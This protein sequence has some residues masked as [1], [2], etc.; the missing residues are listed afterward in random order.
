[1]T[2]FPQLIGA[3][4]IGTPAVDREDDGAAMPIRA[5][6]TGGQITPPVGLRSR[7]LRPIGRLSGLGFRTPAGPGLASHAI[8]R[9]S[10][11]S[12]R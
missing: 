4:P 1:M 12:A 10:S 3:S 5:Q 8:E 11:A 9:R 6:A 2:I 7:A